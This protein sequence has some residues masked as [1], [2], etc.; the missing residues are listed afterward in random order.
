[1]LSVLEAQLQFDSEADEVPPAYDRFSIASCNSPAVLL[2][3]RAV[4]QRSP[5]PKSEDEEPPITIEFIV[6]GKQ[7]TLKPRPLG[8]WYDVEAVQAAV[9][10]A[11]ETAGKSERILAVEST[12]QEATFVFG[13]PAA[14][15]EIAKEYSFP[16]ASGA[17]DA[18]QQGKE[19]E[20]R[21]VETLKKRNDASDEE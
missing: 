6:T 12:G 21:A 14:W 13:P 8:D 2:P 1:L 7:F 16:L 9:N 20:K 15:Q 19:F 10:R 17:S 18:V 11:L 4:Q 5:K 3:P